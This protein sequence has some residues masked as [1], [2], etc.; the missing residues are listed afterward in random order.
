MT[1]PCILPSGGKRLIHILRML[2]AKEERHSALQK[3]AHYSVPWAAWIQPETGRR[4]EGRAILIHFLS[5]GLP[6]HLDSRAGTGRLSQPIS[7][8]TV[9]AIYAAL[10]WGKNI[11]QEKGKLSFHKA[12]EIKK[13]QERGWTR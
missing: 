3:I 11:T 10:K 6:R 12:P 9:G 7:S 4:T 5:A 1:S 2:N 13:E 8:V